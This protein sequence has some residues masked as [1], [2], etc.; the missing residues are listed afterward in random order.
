VSEIANSEPAP[1]LSLGRRAATVAWALALALIVTVAGAIVAFGLGMIGL[2]LYG[3][4]R[5]EESLTQVDEVLLKQAPIALLCGAFTVLSTYSVLVRLV[6]KRDRVELAPK[7]AWREAARG[8]GL[9]VAAFAL[10]MAVLTLIGAVTWGPPSL[11]DWRWAIPDRLVTGIAGGVV[12]AV[13]VQGVLTRLLAKALGPIPAVVLAAVLVACFYPASDGPLLL[14]QRLGALLGGAI[15]AL[16]YLR[17]GR[18]WLGMGLAGAWGALVQLVTGGYALE[19]GYDGTT[20]FISEPERGA[21]VSWLRGSSGPESSVPL[22]IGGVLVVGWLAWR[23]W[24]E[25][26]FSRA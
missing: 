19:G 5:P 3:V 9:A 11:V 26:A 22:L 6:E 7:G 17:N 8:A 25:G 13:V 2:Y 16:T 15:L 10:L 18:L 12:M 20:A 21:L 4:M 24:K 14:A 23:A 1:G